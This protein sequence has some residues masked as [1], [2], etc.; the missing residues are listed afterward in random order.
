MSI[1][2]IRVRDKF[3]M[4]LPRAL[5]EHVKPGEYLACEILEDGSAVLA[6]AMIQ[7]KKLKDVARLRTASGSRSKKEAHEMANEVARLDDTE[8]IGEISVKWGSRE[9]SSRKS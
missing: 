3:Q 2:M 5:Q 8:G 7:M 4:T 1:E 9:K 6:P